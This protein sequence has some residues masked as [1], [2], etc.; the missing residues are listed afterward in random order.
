MIKAKNLTVEFPLYRIQKN[1][2]FTILNTITGGKLL[3]DDNQY[4]SV[5]SLK[6]LNFEINEGDRVG[7]LGHNGAGKSTLLRVL[8]GVYTPTSGEIIVDGKVTPLLHQT[9]GMEV[10]DSGLENIVNCG[11]MLG[12][13][14]D[15]INEKIEDIIEFSGLGEYIHLPIR[16]YS[17]GMQAR[18]SFSLIT[19]IEPDI[20]LLDEGIGAADI[21][22]SRKA[23]E[24]SKKLIEKTNSLFLASHSIDLIKSMCNKA[25]VLHHGELIYLGNLKEGIKEYNNIID[26]E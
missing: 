13:T 26:F 11:M 4:S 14:L 15:Q 7:L 19:A 18:L 20:L 17:A 3:S 16:T 2:R 10:E 21:N 1:L 5:T 6:D 23:A 8:A 24:R 9:P 22:F 12:M 25:L